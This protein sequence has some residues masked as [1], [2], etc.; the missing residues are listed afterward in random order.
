MR[1]DEESLFAEIEALLV[2]KLNTKLAAIDTEKDDGITTPTVKSQAYFL[3]TLNDACANF[4]PFIVMGENS[5]GPVVSGPYTAEVMTIGITVIIADNG[6]NNLDKMLFRYRRALKEVF[7]EN[8][9]LVNNGN[10]MTVAGLTPVPL[11]AIDS[12]ATYKAIGIT[13]ETSIG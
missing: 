12:S 6:R 7:E 11:E 13:V 2:S 5:N 9:Q 1:Y 10:K 4:D 3:H 8:Y